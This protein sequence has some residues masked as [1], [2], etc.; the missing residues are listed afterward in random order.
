MKDSVYIVINETREAGA[1]SKKRSEFSAWTMTVSCA[2]KHKHKYLK[3][4]LPSVVGM[5][6]DLIAALLDVA[7]KG[8]LVALNMI[9]EKQDDL[10]IFCPYCARRLEVRHGYIQKRA[11]GGL[12]WCVPVEELPVQKQEDI[13]EMTLHVMGLMNNQP[14]DEKKD[15]RRSGKRV[16]EHTHKNRGGFH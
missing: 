2:A 16:E 14:L 1:M 9:N 3:D 13:K 15:G 7:K 11:S 12:K 4:P 10:V 5:G 8:W 6:T